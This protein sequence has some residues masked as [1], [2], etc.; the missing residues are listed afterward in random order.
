[1]GDNLQIL[2]SG[3][4]V[5][6]TDVVTRNG[7]VEHQ[8]VVKVALGADGVFTGLLG[9][10]ATLIGKVGLDQVTPGANRVTAQPY[11]QALA[12]G[13]IVGHAPFAKLGYNAAVGSTE[14]DIWEQSNVYVF[15]AA[16]MRMEV[17]SSSANDT[18]AGTGVQKVKVT[19]LDNTYAER[20]E[21]INLNGATPV[22]MAATNILRVNSLRAT[23]VGTGKAAA[24]TITCR[25][26]GGAATV[27]MSIAAG[28][29]RERC[30][31]YTVPL[32]KTL[33][34]TS[35]AISSGHTTAGK[36]VRWTGRATMD[37]TDGAVIGFFQPWFEMITM[38]ASFYREF[39]MPI[40]FPATCDIKMSATSDG[41]TSFTVCALRG[42]LE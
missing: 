5:T 3:G 17:V 8:P 24:G 42:W 32:G 22:A 41:A 9:D 6:A 38:D 14:E 10:G 13:E 40:K 28:F 33:Y 4:A 23:Q 16:P 18:L 21:T 19:Y 29:T 36:V 25:M 1:M 39:E 7:V 31:V 34:V 11:L 12:E 26:I 37:D 30:L 20:T 15:P 35:I 2:G 27:Y